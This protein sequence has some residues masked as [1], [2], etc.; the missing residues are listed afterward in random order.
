MNLKLLPVLI[1]LCLSACA[2]TS[3]KGEL[4]VSDLDAFRANVQMQAKRQTLPNGK[5]YCAELA[6]TDEQQEDCLGDLEDG[7]WHANNRIESIARQV[8]NFVARM[9]LQRNPCKWWQRCPKN[10]ATP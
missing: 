10:S 3:P 1:A 6:R 9:K 4:P 2:T 7:L 5:E 8:Y